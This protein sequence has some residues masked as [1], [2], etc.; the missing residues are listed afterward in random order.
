MFSNNNMKI[1]FPKIKKLNFSEISYR[2]HINR[3]TIL[4]ALIVCIYLIYFIYFNLYQTVTEAQQVIILRQ[5][6]APESLDIDK[7][8]KALANLEKRATSTEAIDIEKIKNF[9]SEKN[10]IDNLLST[11]TSTN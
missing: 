4:I 6:V 3:L 10:T 2:K 9:F 7:I 11:S 1:K 8:E 5:E